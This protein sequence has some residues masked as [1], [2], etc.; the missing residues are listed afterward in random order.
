MTSYLNK[1]RPLKDQRPFP[2]G[3]SS[4]I[5]YRIVQTYQ[6]HE[7]Q[8]LFPELFKKGKEIFSVL[9]ESLS[10]EKYYFYLSTTLVLTIFSTIFY[11][12]LFLLSYT[13][14]SL[15]PCLPPFSPSISPVNPNLL[16]ISYYFHLPV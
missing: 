14:F 15:L 1:L 7:I 10:S 5:L 16:R 2:V 13:F 9:L 11:F 4:N 3:I 8:Q 12:L 6:I